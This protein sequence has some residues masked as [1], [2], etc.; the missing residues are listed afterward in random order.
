[1]APISTRGW[2]L[3]FWFWLVF[4][5]LVLFVGFT[6]W[7][8]KPYI[9]RGV[10]LAD[11][12]DFFTVLL[13]RGDIGGQLFARP[14]SDKGA[15]ILPFIKYGQRD[16][17]GI[18]FALPLG[19]E[20]QGEY[21]EVTTRLAAHGFPIE[22]VPPSDEEPREFTIVNLGADVDEATRLVE[23]ALEGLAASGQRLD[24]W[25]MGVGAGPARIRGGE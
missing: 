4:S 10:I 19:A 18:R 16:A 15:G 8:R 6:W 17:H 12:G 2:A 7:G 21:E 1:M 5:V 3:G 20:N 22:S 14:M 13:E 9:H 11:L 25:F 24:V 23:V